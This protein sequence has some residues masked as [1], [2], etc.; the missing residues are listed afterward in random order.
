MGERVREVVEYLIV[1]P[2]IGRPGRVQGARELVISGTPS[3]P[4]TG[5]AVMLFRFCVFCTMRGSGRE[6]LAIYLI[7]FAHCHNR[8]ETLSRFREA[9]N[10][11]WIL[12]RAQFQQR[13]EQ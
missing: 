6:N 3:L 11:N 12:G 4:C 2:N 5:C 1:Q 13:I 9:T 10:K 8:S 7:A